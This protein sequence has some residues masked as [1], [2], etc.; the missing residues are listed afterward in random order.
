MTRMRR[1]SA[2]Q[3]E[4]ESAETRC[5]RVIRVPVSFTLHAFLLRTGFNL[6]QH[7]DGNGVGSLAVHGEDQIYDATPA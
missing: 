1:I 7:V 4:I 3:P 5:I 6:L 2:D